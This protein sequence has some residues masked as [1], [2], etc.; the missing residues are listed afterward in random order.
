MVSF[1]SLRDW[2]TVVL[3]SYH[4][5]CDCWSVHPSIHPAAEALRFYRVFF[6]LSPAL[7]GAGMGESQP[8]ALAAAVLNCFLCCNDQRSQAGKRLG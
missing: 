1:Y 5:D 3:P 2:R 7:E 8:E 4:H 6:F